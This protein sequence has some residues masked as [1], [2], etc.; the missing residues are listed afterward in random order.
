MEAATDGVMEVIM[1]AA[2]EGATE[3]VVEEGMEEEVVVVVVAR[4]NPLMIKKKPF[5]GER[6]SR[7]NRQK[8]G[9]T[10]IGVWR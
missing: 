8:T 4:D 5:N 3:G 9:R 6:S 7:S 10:T 1:E 2:M